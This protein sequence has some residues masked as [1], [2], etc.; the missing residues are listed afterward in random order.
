MVAN[1]NIK[2]EDLLHKKQEKERKYDQK[3]P[4][5]LNQQFEYNLINR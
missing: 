3:N 5:L 4:T 1:A 2:L